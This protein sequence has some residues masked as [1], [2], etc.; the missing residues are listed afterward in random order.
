MPRTTTAAS[1]RLTAVVAEVLGTGWTPPTEP[2]WPVVFTNEAADLQLTLYPDRRNHRL[3]FTAAS[4]DNPDD[5]ARERFGKYTPDLTGHDTIE[6]WL[7]DGDPDTAADALAVILQRMVEQPLPD[8]DTRPDPLEHERERLA[9]QARELAAHTSY[10]AAGLI[11][12]QPV[13]DEARK[14]AALAQNMAHTATR[15]D[16]LRGYKN[17]HH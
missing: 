17:P 16:E 1:D 13:G 14:L 4:A 9:E 2:D 7:A 10:F 12:H 11:W 5:L 8:R 15:V 6:S 3:V